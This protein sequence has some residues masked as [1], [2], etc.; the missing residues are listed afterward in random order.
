[1]AKKRNSNVIINVVDFSKLGPDDEIIENL[2]EEV[3]GVPP[4]P[5]KIKV[6]KAE[7]KPA[8]KLVKVDPLSVQPVIQLK[9]RVLHQD[10][11][12]EVRLYPSS[13]RTM[14]INNRHYYLP[15]P[16]LIFLRLYTPPRNTRSNWNSRAYDLGFTNL[17]MGFTTDKADKIYHIPLA[18]VSMYCVCLDSNYHYDFPG[19]STFE[20]LIRTFWTTNFF[21]DL[22]GM[23]VYGRKVFG[24]RFHEWQKMTSEQVEKELPNLESMGRAISFDEFKDLQR[25]G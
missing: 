12:R 21:G 10:A 9:Y 16:H 11:R 14:S 13:K 5:I 7:E 3:L 23:S 24:G 2:V 22:E 25:Y 17:F 6:V 1:M 8:I 15:L 4:K 18:G 19:D 20:D